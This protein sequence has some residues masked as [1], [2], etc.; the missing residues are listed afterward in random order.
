MQTDLNR[1]HKVYDGKLNARGVGKTFL[2]IHTLAGL[3]EVGEM[4]IIFI[5]M[6]E[7][8]DIYYLRL[9]IDKIF[10]EHKLMIHTRMNRGFMCNN[11]QIR[12]KLNSELEMILGMYRMCD[13]IRMG[14]N[15]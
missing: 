4:P 14:H 11:K 13:I 6:D 3:V 12:F 9:M 2:K 10:E 1:L 7:W 5:L 15:D 8:H